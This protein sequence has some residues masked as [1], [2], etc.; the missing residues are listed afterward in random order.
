MN[1]LLF[2]RCAARMSIPFLGCA[3]LRRHDLL[4]QMLRS[5]DVPVEKIVVIDNGNTDWTPPPDGP[6]GVHI[7]RMPH[8]LGVAASWNLL[9]KSAPLASYWV[10][11]GHD[12][13]FPEVGGTLQ[14]LADEMDAATGPLFVAVGTFSCFAINASALEM[15]GWFDESFNA[16]FED[17]CMSYRIQLAGVPRI[18]HPPALFHETSSTINSDE[19]LK[20]ENGRTFP[21]NQAYFQAKWGGNPTHERFTTPFDKGGDIRDWTLDVGRL[22]E[23]TWR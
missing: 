8:N 4:D 13:R 6:D 18:N 1:D 16:Y 21:Q 3:V 2:P 22:R 15:V 12:V 14:K 17:D 7:I 19:H 11:V 23:L 9:I 10:I 20:M 5:I